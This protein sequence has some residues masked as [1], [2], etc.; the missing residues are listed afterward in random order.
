VRILSPAAHEPPRD[1]ERCGAA[2]VDAELLRTSIAAAGRH[3]GRIT[4]GG[5]DRD[6]QHEFEGA[7]V[8]GGQQQ[9]D[10]NAEHEIAGADGANEAER[11]PIRRR[12]PY[13]R[14]E[15][16]GATSAVM[17]MAKNA[18]PPNPAA[19]EPITSARGPDRS[20]DRDRIAQHADALDLDLHD[21]TIFKE[22]GGSIANPTPSGVPVA[23]ISPGSSVMPLDKL[24]DDTRDR[25]IIALVLELCWVWPFTRNA[26]FKFCGSVSSTASTIHGPIGHVLSSDFP[27]NHC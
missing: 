25:K 16:P 26:I 14:L 8:A 24:G 2:D 18:N 9:Q 10:D 19:T 27:L 12:R 23:M 1:E 6:G 4:D 5:Q 22:Y 15:R 11:R 21:V 3:C 20:A 7:A 17:P 13:G